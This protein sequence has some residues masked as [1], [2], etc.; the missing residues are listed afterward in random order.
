MKETIGL[1]LFPDH[2]R[3]DVLLLTAVFRAIRHAR[4]NVRLGYMGRFEEL[5][6]NNGDIDGVLNRPSSDSLFDN[7]C[8]PTS[9]VSIDYRPFCQQPL[10]RHI[11]EIMCDLAGVRPASTEPRLML[12]DDEIS[13]GQ[14]IARQIAAE[15]GDRPLVGIHCGASTR[16]REWR[17]EK[18]H[19]LIHRC[20]ALTFVQFHGNA[21]P[22]V[23]GA[24]SAGSGLSL[25]ETAAVL[26]HCTSVVAVDSW[27]NHA[28]AALNVRGVV[29]FGASHP[30]VFGHSIHENVFLSETPCAPCYRPALWA[31]DLVRADSPPYNSEPWECSHRQCLEISPET[32]AGLLNTIVLRRTVDCV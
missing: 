1:T 20:A 7:V 12:T 9:V 13:D 32:V 19:E 29:L 26:A 27:I 14:A 5:L 28:A 2:G 25:R 4:P 16:N 10:K 24:L 6:W 11:V 21:E 17:L 23:Q 30:N 3:G 8:A 18:W 31:G 22:R 15:G